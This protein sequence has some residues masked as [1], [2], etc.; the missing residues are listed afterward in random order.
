MRDLILALTL[1]LVG[2][3][4]LNYEPGFKENKAYTYDYESVFLS[5]LP[6]RGLARAGIKVKCKVEISGIGP[7][8]CLIRVYSLEAAEYNG[9][10][11]RDSFA[12]SSKLTQAFSAQLRN[13]VKFEYSNGRV[14]NLMA[15]DSLSDDGLNFY[16]GLLNVLEF[17]LK[18]SQ[19]TYNLQEAGIDGVCN[20]TYVIQENR[21]ASQIYVT[22]SKDLNSCDERAQMFTGA[23]YTCQCPACREKNKY[24]RATTTYNYKIKSSHE[25]ALIVQ[26]DVQEVHQ[27]TPFNEVTGGDAVVEAWQKLVLSDV[28]K[29]SPEVP[30]T[31]F[32]KR[33]SLRYHFGSE[34]LQLPFQLF[35][36]KN[37][38]SQIVENLRYLV[39]HT[40]ERVSSDAPRKFLQLVQ[41]FRTAN[42]DIYESV[43]K[44][45]SSR[46]VYRR[47]ILDI[48]PAISTQSAIRF[49]RHKIE[50][51]E[52]SDLEGAQAVLVGFHLST[53]TRDVIEEAVPLY[54]FAAEASGRAK[55]EE[56]V[57]AL[58]AFG[59][60]GHPA[61]LKRIMKF[62]PGYAPGA[63]DLPVR[64]QVSAVMALTNLAKRDPRKVQDITLEL[65]LNHKINPQVRM[66]A[67]FVLLQTKP[68][69]P[70][71]VTL[72][73]AM[74]KEPSMQVASFIFT[75]L[76]ALGTSTAPDLQ[77]VMAI[78]ILSP[79][80]DRP[81]YRFSKV[82]R[83]SMFRES[84]MIGMAA[85]FL[86]LNNVGSIFPSIALSKFRAHFVGHIA[87]PLEVGLRAERLQEMLAKRHLPDSDSDSA[88]DV[89]E[90]LK[91]LSDW[92]AQ[93]TDKPL[94]AGYMKMFG[95]E[96]FFGALDKDSMQTLLQALYGPEE[97]IPSIKKFINHLQTGVGIQ[98]S[99]ALLS[100]EVRR[101][102]PTCIGF[103][104]ET[105]L[106]HASFTN[107]AGS[108]QA[109]ISP[110]PSSDF[111][112]A[113]L[114]NANIKV[115]SKLTLSMV[116]DMIFVMG[117]NTHLFQAGLEAHAKVN[118]NLPMN[119][120]ATVNIKDKT[121][122][123]EIPPCSQE[124][125]VITL[126]SK[127]YAVTRNLEDLAAT[128]MT[129]VLLPEAV[130]DI[131]KLSFDSG[132]TSGES[133]KIRG[134]LSSEIISTGSIYSA[135][136]SSQKKASSVRSMCFNASTFGVEFCAEIKSVN[137]AFIRKAPLYYLV[138][139][140]AFKLTCKPV[141]TESSIEKI[142]VTIQAGAQAAAKMVRLVTFEDPETELASG[143]EAIQKMK[144]I[145][146]DPTVQTQEKHVPEMYRL[147]FKSHS[148]NFLGDVLP[149]GLTIVARAVRS[150]NKNQGYQATAYI[151][152]AA[153]KVDMQLVV[154]QLAETNWKACA[155]S[156]VLPLKAQIGAEVMLG[157]TC[158]VKEENFKTFDKVK[159]RCSFSKD[160][161]LVIAQD[162]TAHPKFIIVT[163]KVDP[164][165]YSREV[166]MSILVHQN[167]KIYRNETTVV[168]EAPDQGLANVTFDGS[169]LKVTVVSWMRG[170]TCGICGNNDGQKQNELLM[171]NH[172]LAHS[173]SAFVHSWVLVEETC[174]EG[175][176]LQRRYVKLKGHP[177][178]DG[179]ESTCYSVDRI[180][181]CMRG[182]TPTEKTSV[183]V[184]FSCFPKDSAVSL[185]DWHRSSD[186]KYAAEDIVASVDADTDCSCT[187]DCSS[188]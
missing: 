97:K 72:A 112:L 2:S 114:L 117:T 163:R 74:L 51:K 119:I 64:V 113:D 62:M 38:E 110:T 180:L 44:Q 25:E 175:C 20:T 23:A 107:V 158:E 73:N 89:R 56:M 8:L 177:V 104:M 66:I 130:P 67:A 121:F 127:T 157:A 63:S 9:I 178:I 115:R 144:K 106:Y 88:F 32:Q 123:V 10:W 30:S 46:P 187:D 14:G 96:I 82:F 102:V 131:M 137:A 169:T 5:G 93:T 111:K 185:S 92:K 145:L 52:L 183:K 50:R 151:N 81:G 135:G 105:S 138:G 80:L 41:L 134:R 19:N 21:R 164:R 132:S 35:K 29:H 103:P 155:D 159:Y 31:E 40:H 7:K 6:D 129:P 99:K 124:T 57:L 24:S 176:K 77:V 156:V 85:Q 94:A 126:R 167:I 86:T 68:G 17:T 165:S 11:P 15:P 75:S 61:I 109:Q 39:E 170:R 37:L 70:V 49:L 16:R 27:F 173:C 58:K 136:Q 168:V 133:D 172:R 98:W 55:E 33:G 18:K 26:A 12:R 45:F 47:L 150:D 43:W 140:N 76:R 171:P 59:N 78:R 69:L 101:I 95:Q 153:A 161:N 118:V 28:E 162:C 182:C 13:P 71:L 84:L 141:H 160:C 1:T 188:S 22:K 90:V 53:P 100:A 166:Y 3:Q 186:R 142:Q 4:H 91:T 36:I 42:D 108:V 54:D 184:G 147:V 60:V 128:K 174:A 120:A 116:K 146:D 179:K 122:K 154:V 83:F 79:K 87:E 181:Q 34:L 48:I 125:D 65:F 149:P 148:P 143:K 152:S 139:E